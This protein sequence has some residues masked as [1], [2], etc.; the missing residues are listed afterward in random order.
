M[1][2]R[3]FIEVVAGSIASTWTDGFGGKWELAWLD[4]LSRPSRLAGAEVFK[5][6]GGENT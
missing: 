4:R 6:N 1:R 3:E 5:E 2:R